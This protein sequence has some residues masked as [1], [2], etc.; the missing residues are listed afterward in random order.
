MNDIY[1]LRNS[2]FVKHS[3]NNDSCKLTKVHRFN[4]NKL[5][6][7]AY[8]CAYGKLIDFKRYGDKECDSSLC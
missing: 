3:F 1:S 7:D 4:A 6:Q 2:W 5:L 8:G